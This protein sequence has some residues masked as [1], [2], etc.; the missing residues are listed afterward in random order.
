M[1]KYIVVGY[2]I[3]FD[4]IRIPL[5]LFCSCYFATIAMQMIVFIIHV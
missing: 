3:I 4:C 5:M 1:V 2:N